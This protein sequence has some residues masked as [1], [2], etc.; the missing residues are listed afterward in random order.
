MLK[1]Q[2]LFG[3]AVGG[4]LNTHCS[5]LWATRDF[6]DKVYPFFESD[7]LFPESAFRFV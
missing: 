5:N 3:E 2:V 6:K 4:C 1:V 7:T